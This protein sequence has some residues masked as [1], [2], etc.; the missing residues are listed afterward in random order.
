MECHY[1]V[2]HIVDCQNADCQNVDCYN[3]K[4]HYIH[5]ILLI[6]IMLI[7]IILTV[8]MLTFVMLIVVML[9]V[10]APVSGKHFQYSLKFLGKVL[11][12]LGRLLH[13]SC[14]RERDENLIWGQTV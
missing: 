13:Y 1:S 12:C 11:F 8:V 4:C 3:A 7:V 14:K 6:V 9:T 2:G 5:V 10:E